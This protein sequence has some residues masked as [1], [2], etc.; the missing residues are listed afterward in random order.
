MSNL[1]YGR[2][3]LVVWLLTYGNML[4]FFLIY[5]IEGAKEEYEG[6]CVGG[7]HPGVV[8]SSH[9]NGHLSGHW[10]RF[11]NLGRSVI[12]NFFNIINND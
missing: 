9:T 1:S 11:V 6:I 3:R 2:V 4:K 7:K 5:R 10:P 12:Y 8:V